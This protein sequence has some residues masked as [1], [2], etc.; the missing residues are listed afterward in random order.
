MPNITMVAPFSSA[1]E[2]R[3]RNAIPTTSRLIA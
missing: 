2:T 1:A 3:N